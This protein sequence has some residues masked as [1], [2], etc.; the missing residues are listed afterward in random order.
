M[1]GAFWLLSSI[2]CKSAVCTAD[3][4]FAAGILVGLAA[5]KKDWQA[6]REAADHFLGGKWSL[7]L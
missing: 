3:S 1:W 4:V 5:F 2:I 7:N 6:Q